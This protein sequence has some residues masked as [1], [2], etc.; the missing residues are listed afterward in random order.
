MIVLRIV[1]NGKVKKY[2]GSSN[3]VTPHLD[4]AAKFGVHQ[5]KRAADLFTTYSNVPHMKG[6]QLYNMSTGHVYAEVSEG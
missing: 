3:G 4:D 1:K 6:L 2:I 5:M